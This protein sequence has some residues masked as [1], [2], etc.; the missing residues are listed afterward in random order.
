M[1]YSKKDYENKTDKTDNTDTIPLSKFLDDD[2]ESDDSEDNT[3]IRLPPKNNVIHKPIIGNRPLTD[4]MF[5]ST[6]NYDFKSW[7]KCFPDNQVLLRKLL[8]NTSWNNFF[9]IVERK[10]Y[11]KNMEK[12]LSKTVADK[13]NLILPHGELVF[14]AFNI[15]SLKQIKV[16]F[17]GQDPYPGTNIVNDK[18]IPEAMGLCFSVPHNY[19]KAK[20]LKNIYANLKAFNHIKDEPQGGCLAMW[21]LQG[22]LMINSSFTTLVGQKNVH[23]DL[24]ANFSYDLI[25]YL[26]TKL[27]NIVFIAWGSSAHKLCKDINPNKHCII[28]SSHPSPLSAHSTLNGVIYGPVKDE[29]KRKRVTY[30]SFESSDH[31]GR[32]NTYLKEVNK[33]QIIW[34]LIDI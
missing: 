21:V 16:V 30:P 4:Y 6:N 32:I 28:T 18:N 22:C 23:S 19:P 14:N 15:L 26:N 24:W 11:F 31:F 1:E 13:K 12:I 8:F 3:I 9:D 5:A 27:S 2:E 17:I 7:Q 34:D 25:S 20:S 10:P 29:A 33:P